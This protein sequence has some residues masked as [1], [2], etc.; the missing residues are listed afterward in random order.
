[1]KIFLTINNENSSNNN[2]SENNFENKK[3]FG[4]EARRKGWI[5]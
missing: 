4:F 3:N 2:I 1:M 5:D